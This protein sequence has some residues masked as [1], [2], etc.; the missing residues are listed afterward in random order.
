MGDE[1]QP[2]FPSILVRD[3]DRLLDAVAQLA[4]VDV[5]D[6]LEHGFPPDCSLVDTLSSLNAARRT[7]LSTINSLTFALL[8]AAGVDVAVQ[9]AQ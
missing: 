7:L 2:A 8:E 4:E 3:L 9:Q 6:R 5:P 1:D